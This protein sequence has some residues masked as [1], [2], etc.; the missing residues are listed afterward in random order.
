MMMTE[1]IITQHGLTLEEY[2][3]IKVFLGRE[4]NFLELGLFSVM[5]SEHCGYKNSKLEL[6]K[7]P[8][9][10]SGILI[11]AGEENAGAID[12][13]DDWCI[14]FKMESHNHPSAIEPFQGAATGVGGI[15]RDIFTMGA[16]PIALMDSLRFGRLDEA[17]TRSLMTGVVSGIAHYGNCIGI[18]TVGGEVYFEESYSTNPLVNVFCLG[19]ARKKDLVKGKAVGMGNPVFYVGSSTGRDG[20]HGATFAS[21]ELTEKSHEDRPSVQTADPFMEKLLVEAC[22]ELFKKPGC[23]VGVQDMGAAG[24]TCSTCETA[25]RGNSGIE[26][27]VELVPRR[28]TGMNPYEI[29]LSESQERM[30]VIA[31][32]GKEDEVLKTFEKWGL[33]AALV[34]HVTDTGRMVVKEKGKVVA[35]VPSKALTDEAPLYKRPAKRPAY[36]D[37]VNRLPDLSPEKS[38]YT[39]ELLQL[40]SEP[41]IAS[42]QWV[43]EQYDHMVMDNTVVLPG[44]DAAVLRLKEAGKYLAMSSDCNG[45]YCYLD[46][47]QGTLM[48][49]AEC[50]RNVVISGGRP[51]GLTDC[52]NFGNPLKPESFW[53]LQ[54]A[55]EAIRDACLKFEIPVTGGNVSLYNESPQ[56]AIFP[57]PTMGVVGLI[58]KESD[59][60]TL[61]FKEEGDLIFLTGGFGKGLG[62]SE[63][64][65]RVLDIQKGPLPAFDLDEEWKLQKFILK[66]IQKGWLQSAHDTSEGGLAVA[67]AECAMQGKKGALCELK[68]SGLRGDEILFGESPSRVVVTVKPQLKDDFIKLA[69]DFDANIVQMGMVGGTQLKISYGG[70]LLID[71]K[72]QELEKPW[73]T[74]IENGMKMSV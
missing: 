54:K 33:H 6:K 22:L 3:R 27:D 64:L 73:R 24:L 16:R 29:M 13:G 2:D 12:I 28:E 32:K 38:N 53:M 11:K 10:G 42:K 49:V 62:G 5:W 43:Y 20:I 1:D 51:V 55:I 15:I 48:A 45:R 50:A 58:Q 18:P 40:L 26:I 44:S 65:W 39:N 67:L 59:I 41:N 7:L 21:D 31:Q 74:A 46:A 19:I 56:G 14:V 9:T 37:E 35:D 69:Q 63:Y 70:K 4:P 23:V 61:S 52:L 25:S 17:K 60:T 68:T 36:L 72:W 66:A 71:S 47:Y 57:T 8:T 30:L 34:G